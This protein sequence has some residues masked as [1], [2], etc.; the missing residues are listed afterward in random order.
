MENSL[1]IC[2]K[3]ENKKEKTGLYLFL[4]AHS[5]LKQFMP[6]SSKLITNKMAQRTP[7]EQSTA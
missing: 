7:M 5:S 4:M 1:K 2:K 3:K 6:V